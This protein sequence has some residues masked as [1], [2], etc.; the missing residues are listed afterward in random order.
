MM[1]KKPSFD[2]ATAFHRIASLIRTTGTER[3]ISHWE[4]VEKLV[5]DAVVRE[6]AADTKEAWRTAEKMV[7]VFSPYFTKGY[8]KYNM[9]QYR[10]EFS[11]KRIHGVWAY[12]LKEKE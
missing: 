12:R 7:G 2:A 3:Y 5:D 1:P 11:R 8:T 6:R 9:D 4:L 10:K